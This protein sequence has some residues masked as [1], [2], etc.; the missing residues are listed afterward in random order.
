[1]QGLTAPLLAAGA[2]SVVATGWR[3]GD[4]ETVAF[5]AR[6]YDAL[7]GGAP[8]G[9]ALRAAKLDAIRRGAT[10]GEW[11]AFG[12]VGDA[13]VTLPLQR[14]ARRAPWWIAVGAAAVAAAG[15]YAGTRRG[16]ARAR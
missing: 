15:L 8:V 4:R 7:A 6:F 14:P 9:D 1:V 10:P 13:F 2:R 11:A 3:I 5:V 16:A 12:V